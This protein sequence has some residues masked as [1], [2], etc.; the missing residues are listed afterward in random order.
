MQVN[1][2]LYM[3]SAEMYF[4]LVAELLQNVCNLQVEYNVITEIVNK[5]FTYN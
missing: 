3:A 5:N 4:L 2:S 1:S